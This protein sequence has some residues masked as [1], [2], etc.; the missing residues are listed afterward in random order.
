MWILSD[1]RRMLRDSARG[2]LEGQA[3][4]SHV[5]QLRDAEDPRGYAPALWQ[6]FADQ[7]Y[8]A[9]LVPEAHGGIGLGVTEAGLI[10]E[11][12]GRTLRPT[13]FFSTAVLAAWLLRE[14]GSQAQQAC[15][16]P[17]IAAAETVVAV[18]VDEHA[19]HRPDRLRAIAKRDGDGWRVD[20]RKQAVVDGHVAD[21]LLVAARCEG[22]IAWLLVPRDSDGVTVERTVMVDSHNAARV[23]FENVRLGADALVGTVAGGAALL[24][25]VLDVGRVVVAAELLGIA[26]EVFTRTVAYLKERRQ[27]GRF[28]GEFQALQHRAAELWCDLELTRA[29]LRQA[30]A[31]VD[32]GAPEAALHVAQAKARAALT[33]ERAVAEGVQMHGGIGVTDELDIGLFLKR[34]RVLQALFGDAFSQLDRV[35]ILTGY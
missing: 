9:T 35:A 31:D 29:I 4:A 21:A 18:A 5:R 1:E 6:A 7:G 8:S 13:P 32:A 17:R 26:D 25:R 20:G 10:A 27:F 2:F 30:L 12:L 24:D 19:I 34:A 28:I 16:L 23:Q 3:P 33:A 22:G 11:E 15:W 14:A